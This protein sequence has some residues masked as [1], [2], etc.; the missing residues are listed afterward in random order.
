MKKVLKVG[1][2]ATGV[3]ALGGLV[4]LGLKKA[5]EIK[6]SMALLGPEEE[7]DCPCM[8]SNC[9]CDEGCN[10][11]CESDTTYECEPGCVCEEG[12][13]ECC[14]NLKEQAESE[15]VAKTDEPTVE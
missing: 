7:D 10:C 1:L 13:V 15:N 4:Y 14:T 6:D 3:V 8:T 9:D 2:I 11:D 12:C 5:K